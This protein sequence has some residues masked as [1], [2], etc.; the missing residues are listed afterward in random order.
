[1]IDVRPATPA[2]RDVIVEFNRAMAR[3]TEDKGLDP[4]V[5]REGVAAILR[6]PMKGRYFVAESPKGEVVGQ[7]SVTYEWSDWRNGAVWWIQ[8]VYVAPEHRGTG[9]YSRLHRHIREAARREGAIGLRLYVEREN[10]GAQE[11]YRA[12]GMEEA[13]YLMFQDLWGI[14]GL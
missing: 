5:V 8:S 4:E 7:A 13:A 6:D 1:M 10:R 2:D 14:P 9:V 11:A 12:L 3:E